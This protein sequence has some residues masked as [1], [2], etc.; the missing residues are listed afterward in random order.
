LI[1]DELG[2][3]FASEREETERTLVDCSGNS[4]TLLNSGFSDFQSE[5]LPSGNGT[6]TGVLLREND[7]FQLVIGSLNDMIFDQERC[8]EIVSEFTSNT[9]FISEIADP[10]NN[11]KARFVELYNSSN[12][13]L[14]LKGWRLLRYTN[15]DIEVSSSIDLSAFTIQ[16]ES[17]F[18]ISPNAMEF[19]NVYGFPPDMGVGVNSPAD[20]N[21][22][23][24]LQL[25][26]PFGTVIDVFGIVGED[27]SET[28]HEFEDGRAVR[29]V[30]VEKANSLYTFDEWRIFNDT[31]SAGTI[32]ETKNAP[33]DFTPGIRN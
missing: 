1:E 17:T 8:V 23:D 30:K 4:V 16:E 12:V 14:P 2:E 26:D 15:D 28:N 24:N 13:A 29:N 27:G 5:V 20:S 11:S 6:I 18:V 25:I 3:L 32:N 33:E 31:G 21:G 9:I 22:D 10:N 19:E 7:D